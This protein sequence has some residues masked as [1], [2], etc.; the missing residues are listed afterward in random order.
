MHK[1][2]IL[3]SPS[4]DRYYVG[5]SEN[6]DQRLEWHK[7]K[8]FEKSFTKKAD[9]WLVFLTIVCLSRKHADNIENHIKRMK[10]RR[11][12]ETLKKY[13]EIAQRLKTKYPE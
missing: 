10:S 5:Q 12:L 7:D 13:P 6:F 2:Y 8:L 3:Y 4:I 9:D 11:Y 1:V